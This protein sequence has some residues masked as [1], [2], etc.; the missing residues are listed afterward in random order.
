MEGEIVAAVVGAVFFLTM[1]GVVLMR[2]ISK[3]LSQFLEVLIE[4]RRGERKSISDVE[5]RRLLESLDDRLAALEQRVNFTEE[6]LSSQDA[7]RSLSG[8]NAAI[9]EHTDKRRG[10]SDPRTG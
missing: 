10:D 4:E 9:T 3:R 8:S 2:P 6:L 7:R 5:T 1:G